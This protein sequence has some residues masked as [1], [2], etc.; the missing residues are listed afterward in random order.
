MMAIQFVLAGTMALL[1]AAT[2]VTLNEQLEAALYAE[3]Q[4][5]DLADAVARYRQILADFG[6]NQAVAGQAQARLAL[7][8]LKLGQEDEALAAYRALLADFGAFGGAAPEACNTFTAH[9]RESEITEPY[10][11]WIYF[12]DRT[13]D[14]GPRLLITL[15]GR[16]A[17]VELK[18]AADATVIQYLSTEAWGALPQLCV[19]Q[20]D[21]NRSFIRFNLPDD[22][23]AREVIRAELLLMS[24]QPSNP[25]TE[26]FCV[27][28]FGVDDPW[29]ETTITWM[30]QPPVRPEEQAS[31]VVLLGDADSATHRIDITNLTRAWLDGTLP[32]A[33][34]SL[35]VASAIYGPAPLDLRNQRNP[36]PEEWVT[37]MDLDGLWQRMV[38]G[39]IG[40]PHLAGLWALIHRG[41]EIEDHS[42][43]AILARA[44]AALAN[45]EAN[46]YERWLS[47]LLLSGIGG[48]T[49]IPALLEALDGPESGVRTGVWM[50]LGAAAAGDALPQASLEAAVAKESSPRVIAAAQKAMAGK[51]QWHLDPEPV[52]PGEEAAKS[53]GWVLA[54]NA[55]NDYQLTQQDGPA[56]ASAYVLRSRVTSIG[57]KRFGTMLKEVDAAPYR[58]K[59]LRLAASVEARDVADWAGLW[60]RID[61]ANGRPAGFDNMQ[62]RPITGTAAA[63]DYA[64]VLQVPEEAKTVVCGILLRGLGEVVLTEP[65][66]EI[67]G[68]DVPLTQMGPEVP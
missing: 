19:S 8:L 12:D 66:L 27:A 17:P 14:S 7:C 49:S 48:E 2:T 36:F 30:N 42:R 46:G 25:I 63:T 62:D 54:G 16:D 6:E 47:A 18:A 41:R 68:D 58:G 59:R 10:N 23:S 20:P 33:G 67:V 34:L 45:K 32:N 60:M 50:A 56:G 4:R 55:S 40:Q 28:V 44:T 24:H 22:L 43:E 35:R 13:S 37:T 53:A 64:V 39:E 1:G 29:E 38:Y 61:D 5:G 57:E 11:R 31:F 9:F 3:E 65:E 52:D 51:Y 15:A 21:H 26:P